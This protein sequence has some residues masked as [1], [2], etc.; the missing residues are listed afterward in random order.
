MLA[1]SHHPKRYVRNLP[2]AY[3]GAVALSHYQRL[4][5]LDFFTGKRLN[6]WLLHLRVVASEPLCPS[7]PAVNAQRR[8]A[9]L[10]VFAV[11]E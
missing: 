7:R 11:A 5:F 4:S 3:A 6:G 1:R 10:G 9:L 2:G 8:V